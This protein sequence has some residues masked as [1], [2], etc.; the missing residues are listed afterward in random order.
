MAAPNWKKVNAAA[1][2]TECSPRHVQS[3]IEDAQRDIAELVE[4]LRGLIDHCHEQERE[5]TEEY[6]GVAYAGESLPLC[7]ARALLAKIDGEAA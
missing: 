1:I 6:Y 5:L 2:A 7:N 3:V 4:A